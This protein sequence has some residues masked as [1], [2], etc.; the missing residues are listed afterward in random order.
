[1]TSLPL[2]LTKS[3][4][5]VWRQRMVRW[6]HTIGRHHTNRGG[7]S[8]LFVWRLRTV[9]WLHTVGK[10]HTNGGDSSSLFVWRLRTVRWLHTV[11]RRHR[12]GGDS[13][14]QVCM[15]FTYGM[16]A[17]SSRFQVLLPHFTHC[18]YNGMCNWYQTFVIFR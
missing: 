1:M 15:A 12:N 14:S 11:G 16:L 7:K 18:S 10:H 13:S 6:L 5:F 3:S 17:L 4:L 2:L 8:S 9:R